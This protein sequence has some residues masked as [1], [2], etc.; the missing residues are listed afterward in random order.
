MATANYTWPIAALDPSEANLAPIE[1]LNGTNV[2]KLVVAFDDTTEEFRV[3]QCTIPTDIDTSGTITLRLVGH[4]ATVD[5]TNNLIKATFGYLIVAD[6][7]D[8]DQAYTDVSQD[9]FATD[10]TQDDIDTITW[11]VAATSFTANGLLSFRVSR[12]VPATSA[13]KL[14][15]D[16][17]GHVFTIQF[18]LT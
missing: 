17:Y 12:E 9:D 1:K 14:V 2:D 18:P 16:W 8:W 7:A 5:A 15:G 6:T 11:T 10:G 3:G 4:A 13:T